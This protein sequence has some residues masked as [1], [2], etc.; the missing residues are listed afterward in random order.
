M[1][2]VLFKGIEW[3]RRLTVTAS[4]VR[5]NLDGRTLLVQIRRRTG[6]A[7]LVQLT[8]GAGITTLTQSG[9]TEGQADVVISAL[10]SASLDAPAAHTIVVLL[11]GQVVLPPTKLPVRSL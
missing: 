6:E 3:T 9:E 8:E 2:F 5:R 4:G 1:A 10:A 7:A 11:D